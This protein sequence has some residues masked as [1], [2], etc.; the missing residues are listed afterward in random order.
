MNDV[1]IPKVQVV[2]TDPDYS[3]SAGTDLSFLSDN[4]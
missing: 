1:T 3:E 2:Q 4:N